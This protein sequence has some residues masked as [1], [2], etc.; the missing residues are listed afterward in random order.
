VLNGILV[1]NA[2]AIVV[3]GDVAKK[4]VGE[5]ILNIAL[6]TSVLPREAERPAAG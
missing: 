4:E 6:R 3:G 5:G 2:S 1:D